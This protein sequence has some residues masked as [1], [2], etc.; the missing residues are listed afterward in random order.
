MPLKELYKY[1]LILLIF[2]SSELLYGT[3]LNISIKSGETIVAHKTFLGINY[4]KNNEGTDELVFDTKDNNNFLLEIEPS[5]DT[6]YFLNSISVACTSKKLK[7]FAFEINWDFLEVQSLKELYTALDSNGNMV[8]DDLKESDSKYWGQKK[9]FF[10]KQTREC[11]NIDFKKAGTGGV[12]YILIE[13]SGDDSFKLPLRFERKNPVDKEKN[14]KEEEF[15]FKELNLKIY[16]WNGDSWK[17]LGEIP[18]LFRYNNKKIAIKFYKDL[19]WK[20]RVELMSGTS[21]LNSIHLA[22]A[23][24]VILKNINI[25]QLPSS[26][27]AIDSNYLKITPDEKFYKTLKLGKNNLCLLK[28]NGYFEVR[29]DKNNI[30]KG[31]DDIMNRFLSRIKFWFKGGSYAKELHF[32]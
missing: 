4:L 16:Q 7:N 31:I 23:S 21:K 9:S 24:K 29:E 17:K 30:P 14:D 26:L 11:V 10:K 27:K 25:A 20:F 32:L 13:Y 15:N 8:G 1:I 2:V 19:P 6:V 18:P 5:H 28:A 3:G 12:D 22:S